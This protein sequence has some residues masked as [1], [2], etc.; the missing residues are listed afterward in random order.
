MAALQAY[1]RDIGWSVKTCMN[2]MNGPDQVIRVM[3]PAVLHLGHAWPVLARAL[4]REI[5]V[6]AG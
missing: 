1:F 4:K 6:A 5:G 2:C 3:P